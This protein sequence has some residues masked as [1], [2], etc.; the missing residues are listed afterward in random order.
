M[1]S[2]TTARRSRWCICSNPKA[3]HARDFANSHKWPAAAWPGRR[4]R[5]GRLYTTL[6]C[7]RTVVHTDPWSV[8]RLKHCIYHITDFK[9][10]DF[11]RFFP[12][13]FNQIPRV[14]SKDD[15]SAVLFSMAVPMS[16]RRA[17][18]NCHFPYLAHFLKDFPTF[19]DDPK[20]PEN[21]RFSRFVDTL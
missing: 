15:I 2:R 16:N 8:K 20:F 5:H 13:Y 17:T 4:V 19:P 6:C 1:G 11:S 7:T 12:D 3:F 10:P 14:R 18:F 9:F 21:S